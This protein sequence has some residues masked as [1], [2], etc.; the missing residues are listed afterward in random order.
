MAVKFHSWDHE[1]RQDGTMVVIH[2]HHQKGEILHIGTGTI[3]FRSVKD[4]LLGNAREKKN[5]IRPTE[6]GGG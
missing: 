2:L 1:R 3:I 4:I 6:N 5:R